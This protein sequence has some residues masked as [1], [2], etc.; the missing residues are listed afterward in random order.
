MTLL[1]NGLLNPVDD[2]FAFAQEVYRFS[3]YTAELEAELAAI[4]SESIAVS[5]MANQLEL[6]AQ[7]LTSESAALQTRR[8]QLMAEQTALD[9]RSQAHN[10]NPPSPWNIPA[11]IAYNAEKV[12]LDAAWQAFLP[13][14]RQWERD[15]ADYQ[16]RKTEHDAKVQANNRQAADLQTRRAA[17]NTNL[18]NFQTRTEGY[19]NAIDQGLHD[20]SNYYAPRITSGHAWAKHGPE[21]TGSRISGINSPADM[22]AAIRDTIMNADQ[23][24]PI[25]SFRQGARGA[26][27]DSS[28][29]ML[30]IIDR[31]KPDG[32]TFFQPKGQPLGNYFDR[33]VR[34]EKAVS[35]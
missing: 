3:A 8:S 35:L 21:G 7:S 29:D 6:E 24:V 33:L 18:A 27:Y 20:L 26:F 28:K 19:E 17:Y 2:P 23:K 22:E 11:V 34:N 9:I 4:E 12:A 10:A 14:A 1:P 13:K 30:V 15:D 5:A 25:F 32:G 31:A 16:R